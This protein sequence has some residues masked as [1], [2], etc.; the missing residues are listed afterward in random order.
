MRHFVY[1]LG[2]IKRNVNSLTKKKI[3]VISFIF[4]QT[5]KTLARA[6]VT[7]THVPRSRI[8]TT[9][10]PT[11]SQKYKARNISGEIVTKRN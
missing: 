4:I 10:E 3:N 5:M 9:N 6:V 8:S 7:Y 1:I 11:G 2:E